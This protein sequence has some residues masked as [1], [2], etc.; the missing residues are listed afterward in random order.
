MIKI[1]VITGEASGDFLGASLLK[2]LRIKFDSKTSSQLHFQG[3]GGP[4]MEQEGFVSLID[5]SRISK[6]GFVDILFNIID[7]FDALNTMSKYSMAWKPDLVIT[8]DSPEFSFRLAKRIKSISVETPIIHYVMP[9]IWAWRPNRLQKVRKFVDHILAL[10][11][12]E[13]DLAKKNQITCDFV[14]HPIVTKRIPASQDIAMLRKNLHIKN[15]TPIMAVLP[16]SRI[17]E[18]RNMLP[19]FLE[20]ITRVAA[21]YTDLTFVIPVMRGLEGSVSTQVT[22]FRKKTGLTVLLLEERNSAS[23]IDFEKMKFSLF[24]TAAIALATSGTVV[25]ELARMGVPMVVGYRSYRINELLIKLLVKSKRANLIDIIANTEA[26]P[27]FLFSH[28]N[29][30]N[31]FQAIKS[32][33]NDP[34]LA[35]SQLELTRKVVKSL[36]FGDADPA[37]RAA[38][39]ILKFIHNLD[40]A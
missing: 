37:D 4:L 3:V 28:C 17:S 9:T 18:I 10:F 6:M 24:R 12:F 14:G 38:D 33:L 7:L 31:L 22:K 21:V 25:L 32:I 11:P 13:Q 26:M 5:Q 30:E 20:T 1:L 39:S 23:P 40:K 34:S 27:E 2:S 29:P 35:A 16:G 36:G 15:T 19:I 8:I